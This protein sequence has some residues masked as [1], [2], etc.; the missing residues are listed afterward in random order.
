MPVFVIENIEVHEDETEIIGPQ[1]TDKEK[2]R[3]FAVANG[4]HEIEITAW[5]SNDEGVTWEERGSKT[6]EAN[7]AGALTVGPTVCSVK[8]TGKTIEPGNTSTVDACLVY[9][10]TSG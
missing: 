3:I 10:P 7:N 5:G 4:E 8:L 9:T 1:E 2:N 6:I